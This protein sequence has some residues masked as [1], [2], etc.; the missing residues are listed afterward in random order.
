M[1]MIKHEKNLRD[2]EEAD[3]R[4]PLGHIDSLTPKWVHDFDGTEEKFWVYEERLN[5]GIYEFFRT[6]RPDLMERLEFWKRHLGGAMSWE[7]DYHEDGELLLETERSLVA[8]IQFPGLS[9]FFHLPVGS[10]VAF[11]NTPP[12]LEPGGSVCLTVRSSMYGEDI[13]PPYYCY[14]SPTFGIN[15]AFGREDSRVSRDKFFMKTPEELDEVIIKFADK[16]IEQWEH[17][18]QAIVPFFSVR[19]CAEE[20]K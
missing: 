14:Y 10:W 12:T 9:L 15:G 19:E 16:A 17:A 11:C 20:S 6:T 18:N 4:G 1:S 5:V 7:T 8:H 3:G 13:G 2:P